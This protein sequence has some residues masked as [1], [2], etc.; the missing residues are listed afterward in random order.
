[1]T[2]GK[3]LF[4]QERRAMA[5]AIELPFIEKIPIQLGEISP[6]KRQMPQVRNSLS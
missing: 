3:I 6:L 5:E 2:S 4:E 1:M